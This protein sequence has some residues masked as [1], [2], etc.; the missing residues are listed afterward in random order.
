HP[1]ALPVRSIIRAKGTTM[2]QPPASSSHGVAPFSLGVCSWSLQVKCI[3]ELKRL[4]GQ[5]GVNL[6]QIACGDPHHAAWDEGDG[7]PAAARSS[8]IVMTGAMLGFPGEDYT[9]PQTI[10]QTGGFGDPAPRAERL[11]RL[12]GALR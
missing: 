5:L 11:A 2:P 7:M 1:S 3:A 12:G 6:V 9:T 8:G 4:L 10:K